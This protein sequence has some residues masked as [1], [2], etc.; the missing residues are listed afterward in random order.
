MSRRQKKRT[1]RYT[2]EDAKRTNAS[3]SQETVV[4]QY[5][6]VDRSKVGEWWHERK[7]TI[8]IGAT[9]TAILGGSVWLLVELIRLLL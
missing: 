5:E 4:R 2:G 9:V 8:R 3:T 6:A 7:R 1:K